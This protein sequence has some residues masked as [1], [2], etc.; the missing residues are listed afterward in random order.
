MEQ[1]YQQYGDIAE[2]RMIYISEAHALDG[3][4]PNKI[5]E[6]KNIREHTSIEDR[7]AT[8][9]SLLKDNRLTIPTLVDAM[10]NSVNQRYQAWPDRIFVV[11]SDGLIAVAAERGPRG[12]VPALNE[13]DRWLAEF[14]ESGSEP[15]LPANELPG[16][17][18]SDQRPS[19]PDRS[20]GRT[21]R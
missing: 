3:R 16:S 20:G 18:Q 5:A 17:P 7:C 10:D 19:D 8:A 14:Q 13:V 15:E 21:D 11:R 9:E 2:F 1:M 4:R 12:F 6:E